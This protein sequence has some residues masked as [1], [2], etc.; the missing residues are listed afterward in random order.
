MSKTQ[1]LVPLFAVTVMRDNVRLP[2]PIGKPFEF[3]EEEVADLDRAASAEL[4]AY[5]R[6]IVEA[7]QDDD[8]AATKPAAKPAAKQT[9]KAA[10]K[11]SDL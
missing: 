8:E 2:V 11:D 4:P 5:R 3:T 10:S 9:G 1:T 7:S 6:P